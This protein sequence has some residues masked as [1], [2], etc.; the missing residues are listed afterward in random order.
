MRDMI[1]KIFGFI[2]SIGAIFAVFSKQK[3]KDIPK[4]ALKQKTN[5]NRSKKYG[6][7]DS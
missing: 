2:F 3:K 4:Y 7:C 6:F 1:K 5:I